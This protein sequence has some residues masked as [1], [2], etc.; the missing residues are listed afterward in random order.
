MTD[1]YPPLLHELEAE[2]MAELWDGGERSVREVLDGLNERSEPQRAYT[3]ILTVLQRLHAK[4]MLKRRRRGRMDVYIPAVSRDEYAEAR[5]EL[6][7]DAVVAE[8]GDVAL[9]KFSRRLAEL[10]PKHLRQIRRLESRD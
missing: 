5:A 4:Q 7:V 10:D 8:Y 9:A 6:E 3:T 2:V 1:P